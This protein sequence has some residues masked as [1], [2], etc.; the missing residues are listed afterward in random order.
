MKKEI[1]KQLDRIAKKESKILNK[2]ESKLFKNK[3]E[4][5]I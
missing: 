4:P 1:D 5:A 3:L 2:E